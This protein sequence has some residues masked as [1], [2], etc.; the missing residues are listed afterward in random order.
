MIIGAI[1]MYLAEKYCVMMPATHSQLRY[2]IYLKLYIDYFVSIID[3][4]R[5]YEVVYVGINR[6]T[7]SLL[8]R[9]YI[10]DNSNFIF[11]CFLTI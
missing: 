11:R 6:S 9:I 10:T 4:C 8:H 5:Y 3:N 7:L 1:L 2:G